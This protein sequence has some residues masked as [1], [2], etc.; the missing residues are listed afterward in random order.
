MRPQVNYRTSSGLLRIE[1]V[2]RQPALRILFRSEST[3]MGDVC[4][5]F[6]QF[7]K[8]LSV[9]DIFDG[10]GITSIESGQRDHQYDSSLAY[11]CQDLVALMESRSK[12]FFGKD[13]LAS[14]GSS[15]H[16]AAVHGSWRID[17]NPINGSMDEQ[18]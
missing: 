5:D 18:V 14:L 10:E 1:K 16:H 9:E 12:H 11:C 13:V 15:N 8:Q 7:T 2:G 17:N 6:Y 3:I 4:P